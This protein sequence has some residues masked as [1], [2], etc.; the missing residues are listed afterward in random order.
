M[1]YCISCGAALEQADAFCANCGERVEPDMSS[2]SLSGFASSPSRGADN[3]SWGKSAIQQYAVASNESESDIACTEVWSCGNPQPASSYAPAAGP[4]SDAS[5][6]HQPEFWPMPCYRSESEFVPFEVPGSTP[7]ADPGLALGDDV[8][9]EADSPTVI[10]QEI[11]DDSFPT[12]VVAQERFV[13]TRQKNGERFEL[14][15]PCVIGRGS[16]SDCKVK[17]NPAISRLHAKVYCDDE[18]VIVQDLASTNNTYVDGTEIPGR[19]SAPLPDGSVLRLGD[20]D[21]SFSIEHS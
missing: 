4:L 16:A 19:G 13:L 5:S 21:F 9:S 6:A 3:G 1:K 18:L 15:L 14:V 10:A 12:I 20:E 8:D 11:D 2:G 17:G 7:S